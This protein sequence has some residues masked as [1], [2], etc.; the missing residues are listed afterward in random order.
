MKVAQNFG[1]TRSRAWVRGDKIYSSAEIL[2]IYFS[3][4]E[5]RVAAHG[6][7]SGVLRTTRGG[8]SQACVD[9]ECA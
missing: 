9:I 4:E 2:D 1:A 5:R 3:R 6:E 7:G 8:E